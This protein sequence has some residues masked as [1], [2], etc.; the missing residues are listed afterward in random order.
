MALRTPIWI[1]EASVILG[2]VHTLC[3]IA[4]FIS[5]QHPFLIFHESAKRVLSSTSNEQGQTM[6][7]ITFGINLS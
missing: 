6:I 5:S 7:T 4:V 3:A 1:I 2:K